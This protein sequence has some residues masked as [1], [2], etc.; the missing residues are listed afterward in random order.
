[1]K[2]ENVPLLFRDPLTRMY[3]SN[4]SRFI[5]ETYDVAQ[6][7]VYK[8]LPIPENLQLRMQRKEMMYKRYN[9]AEQIVKQY[10]H[11]R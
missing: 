11:I 5:T 2:S 7:M 8:R 9:Y 1:M 6:I 4:F 10:E 3:Q